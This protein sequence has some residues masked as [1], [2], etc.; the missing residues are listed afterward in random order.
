MA[1]KFETLQI[2][3]LCDEYGG[4]LT[5]PKVAL[6]NLAGDMHRYP[7]RLL[8]V[9]GTRTGSIADVDTYSYDVSDDTWA[10]STRYKPFKWSDTGYGD[11]LNAALFDEDKILVT[12]VGGPNLNTPAAFIFDLT[13]RFEKKRITYFS[14]DDAAFFATRKGASL[15]TLHNG[16]VLRFGGVVRNIYATSK[17]PF[18]AHAMFDPST[19]TWAV[20]NIRMPLLKHALC[21]VLL[22]GTILVSGGAVIDEP[23]SGADYTVMSTDA[24]YILDMASGTVKITGKMMVARARHGGCLLPNGNVFVSGGTVGGPY[25][26]RACE[27]FNVDKEEWTAAAMLPGGRLGH[28]CTLVGDTKIMITGGKDYGMTPSYMYDTTTRNFTLTAQLPLMYFDNYHTI[29]LY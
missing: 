6:E 16:R 15:I 2:N 18:P 9:G 7:T 19:R 14:S 1:A 13:T 17:R 21:V 22:N 20:V 8:T 24:C 10:R 23:T 26:L 25:G 27:E 28:T 12:F 4:A 5:L 29:P 3:L 11:E